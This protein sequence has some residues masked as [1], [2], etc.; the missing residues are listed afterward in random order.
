MRARAA[1]VQTANR[2][3]VLAETEKRPH[4]EEL[5]EGKLA[6]KNLPAGQSPLALEVE[7]RQHLPGDDERAEAGRVLV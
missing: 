3:S 5:I 2:R 4:G 6:V 1:Q 7:G